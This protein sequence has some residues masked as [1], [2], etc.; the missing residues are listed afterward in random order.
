MPTLTVIDKV[1]IQNIS[2]PVVYRPSVN[3]VE[4]KNAGALLSDGNIS[5][6][7]EYD[8]NKSSWKGNVKVAHL[9]FGKLAT[10]FL[11]EGELVGSI[12]A[13]VIMNGELGTKTNGM[14]ETS[15]ANGKFSTTPGYFHKMAMLETITPTKRISFENASG[16]F[17]WNGTDIFLNPGTRIKAGNDEP[18]YRYVAANGSL[19][20]PGKGLK[21][22]CDGRFDL[23]ILD[24]LLGAM[25]GVF[26]YMTG[27]LGRNVLKDAAG[28]VLGIKR[29]DLQNVSS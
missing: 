7:F 8:I 21:L 11:P 22:M 28:R 6:G 16:T 18:L 5:S 27:S 24:Q 26:Q 17:F 10:P 25:K 23:K 3:K 15:Y 1:K 12:D 14:M 2:V 20:I 29:R 4:M 9:D 19:G 13:E